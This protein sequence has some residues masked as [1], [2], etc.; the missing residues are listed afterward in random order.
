MWNHRSFSL[1]RDF[2]FVIKSIFFLPE[3]SLEISSSEDVVGHCRGDRYRNNCNN[4]NSR[5]WKPNDFIRDISISSFTWC[6]GNVSGQSSRGGFASGNHRNASDSHVGFS[7]SLGFR[8]YFVYHKWN[9][10]LAVLYH[11]CSDPHC[12]LN[13]PIFG[14]S[15]PSSLPG[16]AHCQQS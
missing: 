8:R 15:S 2:I 1:K 10:Q 16:L 7:Q 6:N 3:R 13:W 4:S 5:T 12:R 11:L 14:H 9:D